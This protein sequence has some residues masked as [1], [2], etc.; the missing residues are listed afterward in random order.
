MCWPIVSVGVRTWKSSSASS[1]GK[2]VGMPEFDTFA[3][4]R[5]EEE[6]LLVGADARRDPALA[7][8]IEW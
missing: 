2:L 3:G 4:E 1:S 5:A 6:R 8:L 7:F